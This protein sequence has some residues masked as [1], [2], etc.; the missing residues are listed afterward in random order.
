M[1]SRFVSKLGTIQSQIILG[2]ALDAM[3]N[4]CCFM[5]AVDIGSP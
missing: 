2:Y 5:F 4:L 1:H 3:Y